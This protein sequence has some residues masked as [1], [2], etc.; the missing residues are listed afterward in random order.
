MPIQNPTYTRAEF[1][2]KIKE[3]YPAYADMEDNDLIDKILE[4]YPVYADQI[5]DDTA[6]EPTEPQGEFDQLQQTVDEITD[7]QEP[8]IVQP[9]VEP[10]VVEEVD[11]RPGKE[12]INEYIRPVPNMSFLVVDPNTGDYGLQLPDFNLDFLKIKPGDDPDPETLTAVESLRN[13]WN[14]SLDQ[15][16]LT[17]DRFYHL[18]EQLFGDTDSINFQAAEKAIAAVEANQ[19]AAGGTLR[20]EDI[21]SAF[22]EK[23]IVKGFAHT[24]AATANAIAAFGTSAIQ[25]GATGGAALAVDIVQGSVRDYTQQRAADLGISY[26]EASKTLGAETI[27][28]VALG[29]LSY[30]FEKAGI[31]GVGK[32]INAISNEAKKSFF[33]ILNAGTK[34]GLTELAQGTVDAFNRGIAKDDVKALEKELETFYKEEALETTLQGIVGG[35]GSAGGGR[36][37][38]RLVKAISRDNANIETIDNANKE[39]GIIDG[40]RKTASAEELDAMNAAHRKLEEDRKNA[41]E[42]P[43]RDLVNVNVEGLDE[44]TKLNTEI[45]SLHEQAVTIE[46]SPN[47]T[48]GEK[49][50]LIKNIDNKISELTVQALDVINI[51]NVQKE[52]ANKQRVED[53]KTTTREATNAKDDGVNSAEAVAKAVEVEENKI[54][55]ENTIALDD[56]VNYLLGKYDEEVI[57]V[58]APVEAPVI[59]KKIEQTFNNLKK[60]DKAFNVTK[61]EGKAYAQYFL[62]AATDKGPIGE[63]L[64]IIQK[65]IASPKRGK[66][67][68]NIIQEAVKFENKHGEGTFNKYIDPIGKKELDI[69][70]KSKINYVVKGIREVTAKQAIKNPEGAWALRLS[71]AETF[72]DGTYLIAPA[73]VDDFFYFGGIGESEVHFRPGKIP[74]NLNKITVKN[75]KITN[76]EA[77]DTAPVEKAPPKKPKIKAVVLPRS[78]AYVRTI[79]GKVDKF[80]RGRAKIEFVPISKIGGGFGRVTEID[81]QLT[82]QFGVFSKDDVEHV[83]ADTLLHEP[84]HILYQVAANSQDKTLKGI[85]NRIDQEVLNTQ[86]YQDIANEPKYQGLSEEGR[87][88]EAFA[89]YFGKYGTKK[90][91]EVPSKLRKAISDLINYVKKQ[92][93][94]KI[95]PAELTLDD[96]S[97]ILL[98]DLLAP[99]PTLFGFDGK[100]AK[101]AYKASSEASFLDAEGYEELSEQ[102]KSTP[103]YKRYDKKLN[104]LKTATKSLRGKVYHKIIEDIPND[105]LLVSL[106]DGLSHLLKVSET[107]DD[108]ELQKELLVKVVNDVGGVVNEYLPE[109]T[110]PKTASLIRGNVGWEL[111][112]LGFAGD[113]LQVDKGWKDRDPWKVVSLDK[114]SLLEFIEATSTYPG[115]RPEWK[116]V[117]LTPVAEFTE[118][119]HPLGFPLVNG[120]TDKVKER[121]PT[122]DMLQNINKLSSTPHKANQP[123]LNIVN[124]PEVLALVAA[125]LDKKMKSPEH[126]TGYTKSQRR[127]IDNERKKI[128]AKGLEIG[129]ETFYEPFQFEWRGR[130]NSTNTHWKFQGDQV[131]RSGFLF[132]NAKPLG[133]T[134]YE[135]LLVQAYDSFGE[136]GTTVADRAEKAKAFE[137]DWIDI[138]NNPIKRV[139]D[140]YEAKDNYLFLSTILEIRDANA[141]EEGKYAFPS[142][143]PIQQDATTSVVQHVAGFMKDPIAAK[144]GNLTDTD[145]RY[146]GYLAIGKPVIEGIP[147]PQE[148]D[149]KHYK[150]VNKILDGF[151]KGIKAAQTNV[152]EVNKK[153]KLDISDNRLANKDPRTLKALD[154]LQAAY[155]AKNDWV[156]ENK[157][158][159]MR[160][161]KVHIGRKEAEDKYR[162]RIKGP[163]MIKTYSA[164]ESTVANNIQKSLA[165]DPLFKEGN[166]DRYNFQ[167]AIDLAN[168]GDRV[169]PALKRFNGIWS[170]IGT[171][172]SN[173]NENLSYEA[174]I[175]GFLVDQEYLEAKTVVIEKKNYKGSNDLGSDRLSFR[176]AVDT[177]KINKDQVQTSSAVN[178]IHSFDPQA[179]AYILQKAG[180][181]IN[182]IHDAVASVAADARKL[183]DLFR[184]GYVQIYQGDAL[185]DLIIKALGEKEGKALYAKY[186]KK[187]YIGDNDIAEFRKNDFGIGAGNVVT[188]I[189][190]DENASFLDAEGYDVEND[191]KTDVDIS[192]AALKGKETLPKWYKPSD[193][194]RLLIPPAADDYHGLISL[195]P[196]GI[197]PTN[198]TKKFAENFYEYNERITKLR[199]ELKEVRKELTDSKID[200]GKYSGVSFRGNNLSGAQAIQAYING[201]YSQELFDFINI[202]AV[203]NYVSKLDEYNILKPRDRYD[204]ASPDYDFYEYT[205]KDLYQQIYAPF[206]EEA[207]TVFSPKVMEQITA[208]KGEKFAIALQSSL[209][210]MKGN[211]RYNGADGAALRWNNWI[212]GTVGTTMFLNFR[213]AALQLLSVGNFALESKRPLKVTTELFSP[214]TWALAKKLYSH[215]YLKER[216][217]RAGFDVN[218]DE[219]VH[220]LK[221]ST[222]FSDFTNSILSKGF[223]ATSLVDSVA[224]AWGGAAFVK[225]EKGDREAA[226]KKWVEL[227]EEAQQSSRPDRTSHWQRQNFSKFILAFANTPQ[228]YFRLSQKA[229]REIKQGKN[230]RKNLSKI[231]YYTAIQNMIF[232]SLQA[233]SGA[234]FGWG[235]SDDDEE[236][237]ALISSMTSSVLRGMG[238]YGAVIDTAKNVI[239]EAAR[240]NSKA[241]PDHINSLLKVA[242]ISPP[243]NTKISDLRRIGRSWNWDDDPFATTLAYGPKVTYN[244]PT[245]WV[246][247]KYNAVTALSQEQFTAGQ[248]LMILAGWPEYKFEKSKE[249]QEEEKLKIDFK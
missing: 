3:K 200:L 160:A 188:E 70:K 239:V 175:N 117:Q 155:D 135:D 159:F 56:P 178:V 10:E 41:I 145:V 180:F 120:A 83:K 54:I 177:G 230:V 170:G 242:T 153:V 165:T 132:A 69:F 210:A 154:E 209:D 147:I 246:Y 31:K 217:A 174:P 98:N 208:E 162:K 184:E 8:E 30:R 25:S 37:A 65:Q 181:D 247:K 24:A 23:G 148:D 91:N 199:E 80:F 45:T 234:L 164:G 212:L 168:S 121:T 81:G 204:N 243:F 122:K 66:E 224:I 89:R 63:R 113:G 1:A 134:G 26:E 183:K 123:Y 4:K 88:Q 244:L 233:A 238:I 198:V 173:R 235:D 192:A 34:E 87:K 193:W 18:S 51:A 15:L 146:D 86:E 35:S 104:E 84:G 140:W 39:I 11:Q 47:I 62:D 108:I 32:A 211:K 119:E 141:Y 50:V 237:I 245:D 249:E 48:A 195:L 201:H 166:F 106:G 101:A 220:L 130:I 103:A 57:D 236:E 61:E 137:Q 144:F 76:Y 73:K 2:Q 36:G 186:V 107:A 43:Y 214:S 42:Q 194:T 111:L 206:I 128:I 202:P 187:G 82:L 28:P 79:T 158:S 105:R 114:D 72:S 100:E 75:G 223:I 218:A 109:D 185:K 161:Y 203:D 142:G 77:I 49:E 232:S 92:F 126:L 74:T 124:T 6:I 46:S 151:E 176:Q 216:R 102:V 125:D 7:T 207:S 90:L 94:V 85:H 182:V 116:D 21:P 169:I 5:S 227:S 13:T 240:Q 163:V 12:Y 225:A 16:S 143:L 167:F 219:I 171:R 149:I 196:K 179:L 20:L 19:E 241:R 97:D 115:E 60:Q 127:V 205:Q 150:S 228:Q 197:D 22:K 67:Y 40:A 64:K 59:D 38:R 96:I 68:K 222:N 189:V 131:A 93:G 152:Y 118:F 129:G 9:E 248:K 215:P 112:N 78:D 27:I 191:P 95:N 157:E 17:D 55:N 190:R 156:K 29:T 221:S 53:V 71:A 110:T 52:E 136:V 231:A 14:N 133:E 44:I 139:K 58:S 33:L 229:Y 99:T 172:L 213:S 226:I 138:A